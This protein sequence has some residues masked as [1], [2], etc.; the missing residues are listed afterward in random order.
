[1][2]K[3]VPIFTEETPKTGIALGLLQLHTKYFSPDQFLKVVSHLLQIG[4][5]V[6]LW[7]AKV[8]HL[9]IWMLVNHHILVC[10]RKLRY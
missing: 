3:M 5:D 8:E 7:F 10:C 9:R 1:M 4:A 2:N 6:L